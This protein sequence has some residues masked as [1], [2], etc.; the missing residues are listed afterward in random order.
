MCLLQLQVL[1]LARS[2]EGGEGGI[3]VVSFDKTHTRRV[4]PVYATH[5]ATRLPSPIRTHKWQDTHQRRAWR[6]N[7]ARVHRAKR[8]GGAVSARAPSPEATQGQGGRDTIPEP[9]G[10]GARGVPRAR[11]GREREGPRGARGGREGA[12]GGEGERE[13]SARGGAASARGQGVSRASLTSMQRAANAGVRLPGRGRRLGRRA[14]CGTGRSAAE[15]PGC[16]PAVGV[17][18]RAKPPPLS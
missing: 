14:R 12:G 1:Q 15:G 10:P 6:E 4:S 17:L 7:A 13:G 9:R 18:S 16:L 3:G 2:N 5:V 8:A 11:E